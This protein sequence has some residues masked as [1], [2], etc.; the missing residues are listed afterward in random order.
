MPRRPRS[1]VAR[2]ISSMASGS[3]GMH[4]QEA[5]ELVRVGAHEGGGVVVDLAR[6]PALS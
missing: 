5:D 3:I 6:V 4:R 1:L 2:S